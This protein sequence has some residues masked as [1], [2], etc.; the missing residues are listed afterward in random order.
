M[1]MR[2]VLPVEAEARTGVKE[3]TQRVWSKQG[4]FPK[5]VPLGDGR[6]R[7]YL[8]S[9][10][11]E[12][13]KARVAARDACV[14]KASG[15]RSRLWE[16]IKAGRRDHP[17]TIGRLR[18]LQAAQQV[19]ERDEWIVISKSERAQVQR[20]FERLEDATIFAEDHRSLGLAVTIE[21]VPK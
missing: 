8:E 12:W 2:M 16:D 6:L 18:R 19:A 7:G 13:I 14:G 17:R 5:P 1:S 15:G 3:S 20:T 11:E 21:R 9:E 4:K 10:I